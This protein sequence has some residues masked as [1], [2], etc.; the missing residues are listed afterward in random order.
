[1]SADAEGLKEDD[2]K[3]IRRVEQGVEAGHMICWRSGSHTSSRGP[4][5]D[6][7]PRR[8][9]SAARRCG[10]TGVPLTKMRARRWSGELLPLLHQ[11]PRRCPSQRQ[12]GMASA[13]APPAGWCW[14]L[15]GTAPSRSASPA[16]SVGGTREGGG[17]DV[18]LWFVDV[19]LF[20]E[21]QLSC[22]FLP[23]MRVFNRHIVA[24]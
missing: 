12:S 23:L 13:R 3:I 16:A 21:P 6:T 14:C 4:A 10:C 7:D 11:D 1:M 9:G 8:R 22:L 2:G 20:N 15:A 17:G 19:C 24:L 18:G 5:A